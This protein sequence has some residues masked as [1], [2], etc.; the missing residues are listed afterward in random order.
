MNKHKPTTLYYVHDP[1]CSWCWGFRP[2]WQEIRQNLTDNIRVKYLLGGLAPDSDEIMPIAMQQDIAGYW[3][4]IQQHI[5]NTEFNFDFWQQCE[6]RRS[7]YPACRAVIAA[8]K[9]Q[10]D[11]ELAMIEG[12]QKAYYLDAQNPSNDDTLISLAVNLGLDKTR[13]SED[14]NAQTTQNDLLEEIQFSR[15]IG[16]QGF[17]SMVLEK[18]GQAQLIPLNYNEAQATLDF[19][20]K[21]NKAPSLSAN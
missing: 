10:V 16:A 21:I 20:E 12:I 18:N 2:V 3:R 9:Q 17:P 11:I 19:I 15:S 6:P 4:K 5:P 14:L 1:M 13:F 7:T 8:R